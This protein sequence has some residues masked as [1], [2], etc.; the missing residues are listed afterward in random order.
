MDPSAKLKTLRKAGT[1]V[2]AVNS[3]FRCAAQLNAL[4]GVRLCYRSFCSGIRLYF[5]FCEL[6]NVRPSPVRECVIL[7]WIAM[8]KPGDTYRSYVN[9]VRKD[10][11]YMGEPTDWFTSA[12]LNVIKSL[13]LAGKSNFRF[14]NFLDGSAVFKII[15][16]E[17]TNAN[18]H[19]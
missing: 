2:S 1:P 5:S 4:R 13:R 8:F 17:P 11:F 19:N 18:L 16:L 15:R 6:R 3:F 12:V 7:Q 10:C 9:F 14:P